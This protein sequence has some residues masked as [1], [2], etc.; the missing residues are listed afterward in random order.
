M[1]TS[2]ISAMRADGSIAMGGAGALGL[3]LAMALVQES[4]GEESGA[5]APTTADDKFSMYAFTIA[6]REAMEGCVIVAV[7]LNVLHKAGQDH[8]K[9]WVWFGAITSTVAFLGVGAILIAIFWLGKKGISNAGR[10]AF[11]GVL[12]AFACTILTYISFKF[13]RMKD[14]VMKWQN[15]LVQDKKAAAASGAGPTAEEKT[16]LKAKCTSCFSDVRDALNI[17]HQALDVERTREGGQNSLE[18][19]E[20]VGITF[21][22][23]F[24]EGLETVIFLLVDTTAPAGMAAGA[25]TGAM[26]GI[27]FGIFVLYVGKKF[28]IDP[29]WFF[30]LTTV[31]VFFI[32]AGLST[33]CMIEIEQVPTKQLVKVNHPF[34]LRPA[35]NIGCLHTVFGRI[36]TG[37]I[38]THCLF[39]ESRGFDYW[40]NLREADVGLVFRALL[41]YRATPTYLMCMTYCLYWM[42]VTSFM[43]WRY[44]KGTLFSRFGRAGA[45]GHYQKEAMETKLHSNGVMMAAPMSIFPHGTMA[46]APM[47]VMAPMAPNRMMTGAA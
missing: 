9:K 10:A 16:D 12:A 24:R 14:M 28:L 47:P 42:F 21:S 29:Q 7:L 36:W 11:E 37:V 35:Y 15:K 40:G 1:G 39:P 26:V 38:D 34:F 23:I 5:M 18:W 41:G 44:K 33:Y 27:F 6:F 25:F 8:M 3:L 13:L 43:M 2:Q 46:A 31:F 20:I 22:A 32:A 45:E 4:A 19:K 30:H 17:R